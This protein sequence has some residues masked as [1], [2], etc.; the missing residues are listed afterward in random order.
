MVV[1]RGDFRF[2]TLGQR[3]DTLDA[4]A[5]TLQPVTGAALYPALEAEAQTERGNFQVIHLDRLEACLK[6]ALK[7]Y[8]MPSRPGPPPPTTQP[9]NRYPD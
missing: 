2:A 5:E 6:Q 7:F 4:A 1:E 8:D 3:I 9:P